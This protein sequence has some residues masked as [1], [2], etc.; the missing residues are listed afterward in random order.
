MAKVSASGMYFTEMKKNKAAV[1]KSTPRSRLAH[2]R[3]G[4]SA[5]RPPAPSSI[6]NV[7]TNWKK[8]R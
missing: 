6:G 4:F 7:A 5:L 2:G 3:F 8:N 1:A